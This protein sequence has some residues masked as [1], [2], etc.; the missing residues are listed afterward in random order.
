[1]MGCHAQELSRMA[2]LERPPAG[3]VLDGCEHGGM[4][5]AAGLQG[6]GRTAGRTMSDELFAAALGVETPWYVKDVTF[7]A[8]KR[9]LTVAIDFKKGSRFPYDKSEQQSNQLSKH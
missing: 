5:I 9:L 6:T 2:A 8:G 7:D 4:L 1:M 3:L